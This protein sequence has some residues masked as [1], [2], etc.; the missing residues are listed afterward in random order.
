MEALSFSLPV[1]ATN[2]GAIEDIVI[3]NHNG[4]VLK[5]LNADS[6]AKSIILMSSN[7][8]I[9]KTMS[10]NSYNLYK[11]KYTKDIFEK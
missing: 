8:S 4:Y 11:N 2:V 6:L 7:T 1:I 10:L 3:D 5:N 9:L